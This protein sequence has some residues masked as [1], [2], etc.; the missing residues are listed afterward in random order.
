MNNRSVRGVSRR[1]AVQTTGLAALAA[2]VGIG[3]P[4]A[5]AAAQSSAASGIVGTWHLRVARVPQATAGRVELEHLGVFIPGGV[6]LILDGPIDQ[7]FDQESAD[8][9]GPWGGQWLQL[10][11]GSVRARA[12]QL[13][14]DPRAVVTAQEMSTFTLAYNGATDTLTGTV[15][16]REVGPNG[17]VRRTHTASITATRVGVEG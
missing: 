4:G 14:Y 17:T 10:P 1:V 5:P 8:Y 16:W 15:D 6:F 12:I 2:G 9:P 7:T 13:V 3:N 11:D